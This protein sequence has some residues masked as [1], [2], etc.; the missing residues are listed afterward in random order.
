MAGRRGIEEQGPA[1]AGAMQ[2]AMMIQLKK[3]KRMRTH[4][5]L[6]WVLASILVFP[7]SGLAQETRHYD[8]V[9]EFIRELAETKASQ[10]IATTEFAETQKLGAAE[11]STQ[12]MAGIIRNST[13]VSLK[14]RA[15]NSRLSSMQLKEPY[16]DLIPTIARWNEEKLKL[17]GEMSQIAKT[18]LGGPKPNVDY[19]KLSARMPEITAMME[20]ADESIFRLTPMVFMLLIDPKEDSKGHL[21]HLIITKKEGRQLTGSINNYFGSSLDKKDQNWTVSSA[22]VLRTYL[23]EKGYKYSDDPWE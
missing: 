8:V 13:R 18:F 3:P 20:Y 2:A 22:S 1:R 23:T 12:T 9:T 16:E 19:A 14:L 6:L 17:W 4:I 21:S 11:K 5:A 7:G 10:D 15:S